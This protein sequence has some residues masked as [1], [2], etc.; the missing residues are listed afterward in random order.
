MR[1]RWKKKGGPERV[2]DCERRRLS[3]T[4][5]DKWVA[6][7]TRRWALAEKDA[8]KG[9]DID[10]LSPLKRGGRTTGAK[11]VIYLVRKGG[12]GDVQRGDVLPATTLS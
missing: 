4:T 2:S 7:L 1:E 6:F 3:G 5:R 8:S 11:K 9:V 10:D 12:G